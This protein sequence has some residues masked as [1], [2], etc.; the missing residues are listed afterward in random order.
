MPTFQELMD[1]LMKRTPTLH[2]AVQ[3]V[4]MNPLSIVKSVGAE[5]LDG[6][7]ARFKEH[8]TLFE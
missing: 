5:N 6:M 4:S 1:K 7:S 8:E 3:V 2:K